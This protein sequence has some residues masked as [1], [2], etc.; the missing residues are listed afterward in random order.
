MDLSSTLKN[1]PGN[2]LPSRKLP[3]KVRRHALRRNKKE[4]NKQTNDKRFV[5]VCL[6]RRP[7]HFVTML[8]RPATKITYLNWSFLLTK[9][10]SALIACACVS[11]NPWKSNYQIKNH[12]QSM[13]RTFSLLYYSRSL[14]YLITRAFTQLLS[15]YWVRLVKF[16]TSN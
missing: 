12:F 10:K 8:K 6:V 15:V 7:T 14:V 16:A 9:K 5:T 1:P 3:L 4:R 13:S 2:S 11:A